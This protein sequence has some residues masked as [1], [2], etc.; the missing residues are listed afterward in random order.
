MTMIDVRPADLTMLTDEELAHAWCDDGADAE[1]L[2][3][4]ESRRERARQADRTG[5]AYRRGALE[6]W[7]AAA[8]AQFLRAEAACAGYL[9]NDRGRN[10]TN[11]YGRPDPVR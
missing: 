7:R 8:H 4:E 6:E 9:V 2:T 1:A 3:A 10:R 11:H 5:R